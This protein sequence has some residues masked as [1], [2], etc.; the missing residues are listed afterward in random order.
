MTVLAKFVVDLV[1]YKKIPFTLLPLFLPTGQIT[2][3][4]IS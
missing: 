2:Y 1:G 4:A 3:Y